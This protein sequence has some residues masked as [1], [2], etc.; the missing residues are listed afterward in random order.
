[1]KVSKTLFKADFNLSF[2]CRRCHFEL[3]LKPLT[4]NRNHC[5]QIDIALYYCVQFANSMKEETKITFMKII[6]LSKLDYYFQLVQ[7]EINKYKYNCVGLLNQHLTHRIVSIL[8]FI[9]KESIEYR[10]LVEYLYHFP[11]KKCDFP[12]YFCLQLE[13]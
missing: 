13:K 4:Q 6:V 1:M 11:P 7:W 3:S 2:A 12:L 10:L 8:M 5:T 9:F